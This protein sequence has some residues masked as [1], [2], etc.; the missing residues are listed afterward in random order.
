MEMGEQFTDEEFQESIMALF[1]EA[2]RPFQKATSDIS[3]LNLDTYQKLAK[4][5]G[6]DSRRKLRSNY[7][8]RVYSRSVQG[9][10]RTR[11][12]FRRIEKLD[13]LTEAQH[14]EI[15]QL[16][17]IFHIRIKPVV[18]QIAEL[19]E[20]SRQYRTIMQL[21]DEENAAQEDKIQNHIE[22]REQITKTTM[23]TIDAILG[24]ELVAKLNN[25]PIDQQLERG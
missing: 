13:A 18:L 2:S 22:R 17:K 12:R 21:E 6:P 25:L 19:I 7:F 23:Q 9:M 20:D 8:P 11:E 3:R 14:D 15:K 4:V 5:L 16:Q 24:P 10:R 1:D